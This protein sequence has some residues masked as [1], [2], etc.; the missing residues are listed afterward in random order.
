[1][2]ANRRPTAGALERRGALLHLGHISLHLGKISLQLGGISLQ[3]GG[4][5]LQ[6]GGISLHLGSS[7]APCGSAAAVLAVACIGAVVGNQSRD[8]CRQLITG[9]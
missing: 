8:R 9:K 1:M 2:A 6:R 3:L 5:S 7:R 4:I